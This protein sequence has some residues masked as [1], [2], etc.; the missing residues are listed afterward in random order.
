MR[1][2][3][4][5]PSAGFSQGFAFVALTERAQRTRFWETTKGPPWRGESE[6]APLTSAP[7]IIVPLAN[8]QAYLDRYALP[9][10]AH[11]PLAS[12]A[13][14]PA[15][16]WDID[17]GFGVLMI[18]LSA[19]DLGLGALFFGIFQGQDALMAALGVPHGYRPIGAIALGHPVP[20]ARSVPE[21]PSGRRDLADVI[22]WE[23]W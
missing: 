23:R 5:I 15:P 9:D 21:L 13:H 18:L 7:V 22:K 12:E 8:K 10:K 1:N 17:T 20:G 4:Q 14:W 11:T 16:Y 2:A 19:T 6:S 3:T